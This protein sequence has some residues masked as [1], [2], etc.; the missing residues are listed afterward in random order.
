MMVELEDSHRRKIESLLGRPLTDEELRPSASAAALPEPQRMIVR[1]LQNR[2]AVLGILYV[3]AIVPGI[4]FGEAKNVAYD[5]DRDRIAFT[6][7][8]WSLGARLGRWRFQ[9]ALSQEPPSEILRWCT[10]FIRDNAAPFGCVNETC[11]GDQL[12]LLIFDVNVQTEKGEQTLPSAAMVILTSDACAVDLVFELDVD[13]CAAAPW[14]RLDNGTL[15]AANAPRLAQFLA[16]LRDGLDARLVASDGLLSANESGFVPRPVGAKVPPG[17][18]VLEP[19]DRAR[20]ELALGR[21]LV[22]DE[23][24][25]V[26]SGDPLSAAHQRVIGELAQRQEVLAMLYVRALIADVLF[27]GAHRIVGGEQPAGSNRDRQRATT[28]PITLR[29]V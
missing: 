28:S 20:I 12:A 14:R 10:A 5:V 7:T 9:L 23:L 26:A 21:P 18:D 16:M 24:F 25:R 19:L 22:G 29:P 1:Y 2:G 6:I 8:P 27:P 3:Q 4:P 13:I 11:C 15:A 17:A